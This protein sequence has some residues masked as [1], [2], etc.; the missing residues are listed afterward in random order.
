M[1]GIPDGFQLTG[2]SDGVTLVCG[3]NA[4]G[5]SSTARAI[6]AVL[7]PDEAA[8][9]RLGVCA[10]YRV[11]G[12]LF[13]VE[14]D[15][16]H[17]AVQRD[18]AEARAPELPAPEFRHRYRLSLHELMRCDDADFAREIARQSAGGYDIVAA[19]AALGFEDKPSA[20]RSESA[21]VEQADAEL[22]V[23]KRAQADLEERA[24]DLDDLVR[25]RD[26]AREARERQSLLA[27]A[28]K[29]S[30]AAA[31]AERTRQAVADFPEALANI[32]G[33]EHE[34]L[35]AL[36]EKIRECNGAIDAARVEEESAAAA[37]AGF[38]SDGS[39]E[40]R[41]LTTLHAQL[42]ALREWQGKT[43]EC[44]RH[45]AAVVAHQAEARRVLG[46]HGSAAVTDEQLASIDADTFGELSS[47]ARD[48]ERAR[49]SSDAVDAVL[50]RLADAESPSDIDAVRNGVH[51]LGSWLTEGNGGSRHGYG[52]ALLWGVAALA[53]V[54]WALHAVRWHWAF[55]LLALLALVAAV[56]GAR[57]PPKDD[58]RSGIRQQY[59]RLSL[60]RPTSWDVD[61][62]RKLLDILRT[63]LAEGRLAEQRSELREQAA[64][65]R[66][67]LRERLRP[68]EARGAELAARFG[69]V[70]DTDQRQLSWLS[71]RLSQWQGAALDVAGARGALDAA[72]DQYASSLAPLA[73][74]LQRD[75]KSVV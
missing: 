50:R 13:R 52:A 36:R 61:G 40:P 46:G 22:S 12:S 44:E 58:P 63:R 20:S 71:E 26:E 4:S 8:E 28:V 69:V 25:R 45:L 19:A 3:P 51:L 75:R 56:V 62:V 57:R 11:N 68:L 70:P 55:G 30:A 59:E 17:V 27:L 10:E 47:F 24:R 42:V 49:A 43:A 14:V 32:G 5:K 39:P 73:Q 60:H 9:R 64:R 1:P 67:E 33:N 29:C 21:A 2:L 34:R 65:E 41:E 72:R 54:G 38:L 23:A 53:A 18:G 16:G 37:A 7:W 6:E 66:D 35:C 74:R 31:E 48:A 15:A